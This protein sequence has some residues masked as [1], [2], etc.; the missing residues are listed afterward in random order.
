MIYI[1]DIDGTIAKIDHR[2]HFIQQAEPD[3]NAFYQAAVNDTPIWEVISVARALHEAGGH[4]IIMSTGRSE[5]IRLLT[6]KWL[7]NYRVPFATL[8]MR[9]AGDHREDNIVKSELLDRIIADN[10]TLKIG[11]AFE[12]RQQVVKMYRNRGV[13]VFQVAEGKF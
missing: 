12:D 9:G 3:W 5:D 6:A 4:K 2:L 7:I 1:F 13:K 11:G 10:P 8:Y